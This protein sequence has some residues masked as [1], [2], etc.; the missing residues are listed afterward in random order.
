MVQLGRLRC[1]ALLAPWALAGGVGLLPLSAT[2][3]SKPIARHATADSSMEMVADGLVYPWSIELLPSGGALVSEMVG[4]IQIFG[5][6]WQS[7]FEV[8]GVPTVLN[9]FDIAV[10]PD[11]ESNSL[12]YFSYSAATDD[13]VCFRVMR[14]NLHDNTLEQLEIVMEV[15]ATSPPPFS[16]GRLLF[17]DAET[18]LVSVGDKVGNLSGAQDPQQLFGKTVAVTTVKGKAARTSS[19]EPIGRA[20]VF[21]LG[22]RNIQGLARDPISGAIW[23]SEHGPI[24]GG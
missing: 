16:G 17:L 2:A 7:R 1:V 12:I 18:L 11:Y 4:R 8:S 15:A 14:A 19:S 5:Q 3:E 13:G 22:H 9:L 20:R 24:G 6:D 23:A 21:S 10:H